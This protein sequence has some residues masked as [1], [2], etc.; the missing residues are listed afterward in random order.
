MEFTHKLRLDLKSIIRD[1]VPVKSPKSKTVKE[2]VS[3]SKPPALSLSP[4]SDRKII[5]KKKYN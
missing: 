4:I 3:D 2:T 5:Q 1:E